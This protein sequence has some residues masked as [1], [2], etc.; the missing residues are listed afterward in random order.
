M[1]KLTIGIN[2]L[3]N[4][5]RKIGWDDDQQISIKSS[6]RILEAAKGVDKKKA[7]DW[8]DHGDHT[9]IDEIHI[10]VCNL[11]EALP[12]DVSTDQ[13]IIFNEEGPENDGDK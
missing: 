6:I 11:I 4:L 10:Q 5:A 2:I 9:V 12:E 13:N 1:N 7:Q 8:I 3:T